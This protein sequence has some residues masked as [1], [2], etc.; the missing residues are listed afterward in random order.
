[1]TCVTKNEV[2]CNFLAQLDRALAAYA[3]DFEF[4]IKDLCKALNISRT[5]LHRKLTT[6]SGK[7]T[8]IYIRDFRLSKALELLQ[9]TNLSIRDITYNVGFSDVAYFSRCFKEKYGE[10][11]SEIRKKLKE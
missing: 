11:A 4:G 10:S 3:Y 8:S 1:M 7:S 2:N 5:S 6:C 9:T